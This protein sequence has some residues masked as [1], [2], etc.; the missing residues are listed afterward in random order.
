MANKTNS[1]VIATEYTCYGPAD[2]PPKPLTGADF[3]GLAQKI[4]SYSAWGQTAAPESISAQPV[5]IALVVAITLFAGLVAV[6]AVL[7]LAGYGMKKALALVGQG[8]GRKAPDY[9][10]LFEDVG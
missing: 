2:F 6:V 5:F 8:E 4:E 9:S 7:A 3:S 10:G 1:R